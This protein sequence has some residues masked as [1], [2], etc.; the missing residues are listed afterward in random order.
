[1]KRHYFG[2]IKGELWKGQSIYDPKFFDCNYEDLPNIYKYKRCLCLC[3][4]L[5]IKYCTNCYGSLLEHLE[6]VLDEELIRDEKELIME[7]NHRK[8]TISKD[9]ANY[10]RIMTH[11]IELD[12]NIYDYI[13]NITFDANNFYVYSFDKKKDFNDLSKDKLLLIA[14]WLFGMQIY[15]CLSDNEIC[16]FTI[17][18]LY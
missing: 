18:N 13:D 1:M 15:M 2:S 14:K 11:T 12:I 5:N 3:N 6:S 7:I 4:D 16:E 9:F 17:E 10:V 8:W